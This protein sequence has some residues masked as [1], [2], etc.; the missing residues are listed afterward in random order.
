MAKDRFVQCQ[1][2]EYEGCC[3]KNREATFYDYCQV[4]NL[5]SAKK[6]AKAAKTNTRKQRRDRARRKETGEW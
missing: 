2:Y 6:G 4:C 5:Y 3:S 1:Y